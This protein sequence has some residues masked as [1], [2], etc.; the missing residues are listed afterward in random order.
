MEQENVSGMMLFGIVLAGIVTRNLAVPPP[1]VCQ[2]SLS[3]LLPWLMSVLL[4]FS[5]HYHASSSEDED[6]ETEIERMKAE[7]K[8][9]RKEERAERVA[10]MSK[11][12]GQ[13][14][15]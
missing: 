2:Q 9:R 11:I 8:A 5:G 10:L 3:D 12:E 14:E 1:L 13:M 7:R 4:C 15:S 6:S